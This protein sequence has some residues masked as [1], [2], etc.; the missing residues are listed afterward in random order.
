M[1]ADRQTAELAI[2]RR[3]V[4]EVCLKQGQEWLHDRDSTR[5]FLFTAHIV[6]HLLTYTG[7]FDLG[8]DLAARVSLQHVAYAYYSRPSHL[9]VYGRSPSCSIQAIQLIYLLR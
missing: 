9:H 2:I 6:I 7:E 5:L 3:K 1:P 4:A 8:V